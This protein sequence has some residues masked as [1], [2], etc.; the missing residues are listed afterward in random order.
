MRVF[1]IVASAEERPRAVTVA[2]SLKQIILRVYICMYIY[3]Y[4]Y[5][6]TYT[7]TYIYI[8]ILYI[9][10]YHKVTRVVCT[11]GESNLR[12]TANLLIVALDEVIIPTFSLK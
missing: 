2:V 6:Y 10:Y 7:H 4:I 3:I 9:Y 1:L 11:I 8:Y 5:I 12:N